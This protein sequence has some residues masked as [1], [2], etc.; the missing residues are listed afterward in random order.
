MRIVLGGV[1]GAVVLFVWGFLYWVVLS[2][3]LLPYKHMTDE[4]AVVEVLQENLTETGIYWFPMPQHDPDPDATADEKQAAKE[5]YAERHRQGPLGAVSYLVEGREVMPLSRLAKGFVINFASALIASIMLCCACG[6]RGYA[7]RVAFV[8][9]LGLFV[10]VSVHLIARN[11][12][13][14]P[15]DFTLLKIG[16]SVVGW[17]LAGLAIAA[18]VKPRA[19]T[20][21]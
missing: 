3:R 20:A 21:G 1:L 14:D 18:V 17:L 19:E 16:D 8:F 11:Y 15:L 13:F 4:A 10:A 12:M 5:A 2:E 7:A 6:R 9:G